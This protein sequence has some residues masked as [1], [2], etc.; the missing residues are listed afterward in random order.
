LRIVQVGWSGGGGGPLEEEEEEEEEADGV[1]G[2]GVH[3]VYRV[4]LCA[5]PLPVYDVS[6]FELWMLRLMAA[7]TSK[8]ETLWNV[9]QNTATFELREKNS[10]TP[11][12]TPNPSQPKKIVV[13]TP[14]STP[15][16]KEPVIYHYG[17]SASLI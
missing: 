14:S 8:H 4:A 5:L 1:H 11:I 15:Y 9:E 7:T 6:V 16:H 2:V 3:G 17:N 13:K 12:L 10:K